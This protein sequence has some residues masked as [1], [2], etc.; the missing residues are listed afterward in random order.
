MTR[1]NEIITTMAEEI[2]QYDLDI[3][4][5]DKYIHD[6]LKQV[7]GKKIRLAAL[8]FDR[9][10]MYSAWTV[11]TRKAKEEQDERL[12]KLNAAGTN[13]ASPENRDR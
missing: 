9:A 6:L 5:L 7:E 8:K 10:Q 12:S 11:I 2:K 1:K 13:A 3:G 4:E